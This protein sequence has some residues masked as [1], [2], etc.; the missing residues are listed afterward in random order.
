MTPAAHASPQ[1]PRL[2]IRSAILWALGALAAALLFTV[3]IHRSIGPSSDLWDYSQEAR[4]IE[5]GQGF[6]S[7]YTYPTHLGARDKPP[8]PVRWRMPLYAARGAMAL[9]T[10]APLPLGFLLVV[11]QSHAVLVALVFLL[12]AH[13]GS[14]RAGHIAAAAALA[15]PLFL[16]A[17]S[18]GMSQVPA[19]ALAL[20]VWLFL[21][22][23]RGLATA[24]FA[25]AL[26]AAAW[27]LRGE[28]MLMAPLWAWAA[29]RGPG[30]SAKRAAWFVA[31]Y[32]VLCAPWPIYLA[33]ATGHA[34]SI[35]GNPMLL[36]TPEY[37]G[38][39]S[40]RSYGVAMP[41]A[42]P[43]VLAHPATFAMRWM[44]DFLGFGLDLLGGLGPI[45]VG[46]GIAGLLVRD[47]AG[48]WGSL[49]PTIPFAVAIALQVAA[50]SALERSPRFLV[51]VA[52]LACVMIGIAAAPALDRLRGHR[53]LVA[54]L[55]LLIAERALTVAFQ[56]REAPR[57]F[58]PLAPEAAAALNAAASSGA[59]PRDQLV[60]SDVPDWVAWHADR[61][62]LLLPLARDLARVE[63]DHPTA[64]IFLSPAARARNAADGD[65]T[66]VGIIDRNE[67]IPGFS[68]P[69]FLPGGS[70][71]YVH[72]A[73]ADSTSA[74]NSPSPAPR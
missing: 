22:R 41:A 32:V 47:P 12:G 16:D 37:P 66:W 31:A 65:T 36:Y 54:L 73:A 20:L 34:S 4:Q 45:A 56:T 7:L 29:W 67:P 59:W 30:G 74:S 46:L 14:P 26:A 63:R 11:A 43:Y 50:F 62:A 25:A 38:Y 40:S 10:G 52:P 15:C 19:A 71:L 61:T 72:R 69:V 55:A 8:F 48:R 33:Q 44:K 13:L 28:S 49:R 17:Y 1:A 60:L 68:G 2:P 53:A 6:T 42:I 24:I 9:K 35:Q 21:L 70:R 5:R 57:R 39:S 18:P 23:W 64:A 51:P 3:A 58:P 27:Y